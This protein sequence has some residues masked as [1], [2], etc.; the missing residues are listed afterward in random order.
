MM[1]AESLTAPPGKPEA[2]APVVRE[3]SARRSPR[4]RVVGIERVY[5]YLR[6]RHRRL[7]NTTHPLNRIRSLRPVKLEEHSGGHGVAMPGQVISCCVLTCSQ[8]A[9]TLL[10]ERHLGQM[11]FSPD[12][13]ESG[14]SQQARTSLARACCPTVARVWTVGKLFIQKVQYS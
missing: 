9:S 5:R 4:R 1:L 7:G 14:G 8:A 6:Y 3:E 10:L 12:M 11:R 13:G 2:S